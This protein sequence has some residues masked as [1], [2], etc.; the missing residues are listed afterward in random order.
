[1]APCADDRLALSDPI[2]TARDDGLCGQLIGFDQANQG[3][4][5]KAVRLDIWHGAIPEAILTPL[6]THIRGVVHMPEFNPMDG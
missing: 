3:R 6:S 2:K 5:G 4:G 1:M